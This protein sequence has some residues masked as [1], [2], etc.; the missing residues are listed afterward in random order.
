VTAL[1][2]AVALRLAMAAAYLSLSQWVPYADVVFY[3]A[4]AERSDLGQFPYFHF[5]MEYPPVFPFLVV[6]L[7]L[8]LKA[9]GLVGPGYFYLAVALLISIVD[10]INVLLLFELVRRG[11]GV[12]RA[13]YAA[14]FYAG[15]P[16]AVWYSI[17]WFDALA[18]LALLGSLLA[19]LMRRAAASGVLIALGTLTKVF[20][21]VVLLAGLILI[22]RD[23]ARRVVLAMVVTTL[24]VLVP[25]AFA[26]R[27]LVAASVA[28]LLF[29]EPWETIW[30]VLAGNYTWGIM[31]PIEQRLTAETALTPSDSALGPLT[32]VLQ[33]TLAAVAV[34]AAGSV[35]RAGVREPR[36]VFA[37]VSMGVTALLLGSKGF[38]PQF[39]TWIIPL[40]LLV[41]PNPV[42]V[43]YV[44]ALSICV[45]LTYSPLYHAIGIPMHVTLIAL[46]RT[47]VLAGLFYHLARLIQRVAPLW[48][49]PA[50]A[51]PRPAG[52][53]S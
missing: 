52:T 7:H 11:H 15:L 18:V 4:L 40:V 29:R 23:V 53:F 34:I 1:R 17:G 42:G 5:W 43:A 46:L 48:P 25:L 37:V 32:M 12:R 9:I 33:L 27:D 41:W 6:G 8:G 10:L 36:Y 44:I 16:I 3:R 26:P 50:P 20:P 31:P 19:L 28:A 35:W 30:A 14:L 24:I 39:S 51:R 22:P 13:G 47:V 38:S 45:V 21:I 2:A 49:L